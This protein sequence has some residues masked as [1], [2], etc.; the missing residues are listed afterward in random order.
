LIINEIGA[1]MD[2]KFPAVF[3]KIPE[4]IDQTA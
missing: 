2:I 3:E 1:L 4:A